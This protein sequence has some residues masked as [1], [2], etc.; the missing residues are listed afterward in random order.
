MKNGSRIF[1]RSIPKPGKKS[2]TNVALLVSDQFPLSPLTPLSFGIS[3][4][5][6]FIGPFTVGAF[7]L[8]NKTVGISI[9]VDL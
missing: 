7:G 2:K 9:G 1:M 3:I 5:K 6:N 8:T 4:T